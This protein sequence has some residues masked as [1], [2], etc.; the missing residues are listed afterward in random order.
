MKHVAV[1]ALTLIALLVIIGLLRAPQPASAQNASGKGWVEG[2]VV[3]GDGKPISGMWY[4]GARVKLRATDGKESDA[5]SQPD[6]GGFF[7][8]RDLKPGVYEVFVDEVPGYHPIHIFGYV[9]EADNRT[10]LPVK[11][12][13]GTGLVEYGKPVVPTQKS[14]I[15]SQE[16]AKLQQQIDELKKKNP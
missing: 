10:K 14:I 2:V 12:E 3:D 11:L 15:I 13:K 5:A 7:T 1:V 8:M 16:L 4:G 9:V 6:T